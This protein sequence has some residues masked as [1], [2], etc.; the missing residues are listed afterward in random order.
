MCILKIEK[1]LL[2]C[3]ADRVLG[4]RGMNLMTFQG[5][6]SILP[7]ALS[8]IIQMQKP[9]SSGSNSHPCV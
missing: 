9:M 3:T 6:R 4:F 1:I 5:E 8:V 2:L 7:K